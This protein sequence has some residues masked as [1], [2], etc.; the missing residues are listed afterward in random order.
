MDK[1]KDIIDALESPA[2]FRPAF[3][4]LSTWSSWIV[5][6]KGVYGLSMSPEEVQ[7][8]KECTHRSAPAQ[9]G[10]KEIYC[11]CGRRGGKSRIMSTIAAFEAL[12]GNHAEGLAPGE[13]A[14]IFL[15]AFD[16]TQATQLF[17]YC[18]GLLEPFMTKEEARRI[19]ND[20]IE[21]RDQRTTIMVKAGMFQAV[22][23]FSTAVVLLDELAF[24]R[25]ENSAQPVD[26]LITALTPSLLPNALMIGASTPFGA[27]GYFFE[28]YDE[29]FGKDGDE[30]L[31]W[32]GGT[33]KMNPTYSAKK[34]EKD[35]KRD[36]ARFESEY[37]ALFRQDIENFLP[38]FM[39]EGAMR[40]PDGLDREQELPQPGRAYQAFIDVSGG[41]ADS[42]CLVIGYLDA[43]GKAIVARLEERTS[44]LDPA[45]VTKEYAEIVKSYGVKTVRS[46]RYAGQWP[47]SAWEKQGIRVEL[48]Q[49]SASD[50]YL[51]FVAAL[52]MN[53]VGLIKHD[54]LSV[55]LQQLERR[56]QQG[57][58]D[59][60]THPDGAH[61]DCANVVAGLVAYLLNRRTYT[62]EE[63][64]KMA[65]VP[66]LGPHGA[67]RFMTP[68][69]AEA[70]RRREALAEAE[71][72]LD[73]WMRKS[74][75]NP[76][77]RPGMRPWRG[78]VPKE[79]PPMKVGEVRTVAGVTDAEK[80]GDINE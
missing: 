71:E 20:T 28:Q 64:D 40:R 76:I 1:P 56:T 45:E 12:W 10:H 55:Q 57:G 66:S 8:F 69:M 43:E 34:I 18:R 47:V 44:P 46:D 70:R 80:S 65:Q 2:Y 15:I 23:G 11:V 60:V 9:G 63:L 58:R 67:D 79:Q 38:K 41:R 68:S 39:I 42:Y 49:W 53:R 37:Y 36:K 19:T 74:G 32:H 4:D 25:S 35:I 13:N 72:D 14:F 51:E 30:T 78:W 16:K 54:R 75:C 73:E 17:R 77:V 31:V 29:H 50:L 61:D 5:F 24:A 3:R 21:L 27:Y 7:T 6:L 52:S 59:I 48:S 22:R 33:L 62:E 26:E